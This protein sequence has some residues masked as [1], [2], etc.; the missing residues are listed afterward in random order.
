MFY[1]PLEDETHSERICLLL[2][3]S[4]RVTAA[5]LN[6]HEYALDSRDRASTA[7]RTLIVGGHFMDHLGKP[8]FAIAFGDNSATNVE[9]YF[10]PLQ[11]HR[12]SYCSQESSKQPPD[13][14]CWWPNQWVPTAQSWFNLFAN[15]FFVVVLLVLDRIDHCHMPNSVALTWR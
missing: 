4:D 15:V 9:F 3:F 5:H 14:C 2:V 8:T 1:V 12:K 13:F 10:Y 7:T 6:M 11:C